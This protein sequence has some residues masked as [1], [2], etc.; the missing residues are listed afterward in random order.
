MDTSKLEGL[1]RVEYILSNQSF[2]ESA[3]SFNKDPERCVQAW[4]KIH[5]ISDRS[6]E[7]NMEGVAYTKIKF[8]C[9]RT[10]LINM[11]AMPQIKKEPLKNYTNI[12]PGCSTK[13]EEICTWM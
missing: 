9:G 13:M 5:I 8:R 2:M 7:C 3:F 11:S 1:E 10:Y 6:V 12:C 4:G